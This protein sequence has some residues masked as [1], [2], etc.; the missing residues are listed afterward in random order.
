[1]ARTPRPG[2]A[3]VQCLPYAAPPIG[4]LR[5]QPPRPVQAWKGAK[6]GTRT[7]PRCPQNASPADSNP[8]STAE[9]CLHLNAT[10]PV[11]CPPGGGCR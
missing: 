7:A 8:A 6:D 1:M 2:R 11:P 4:A 10:A 9:D 3:A 5:R